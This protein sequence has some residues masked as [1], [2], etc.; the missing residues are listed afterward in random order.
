VCAD[1]TWSWPPAEEVAKGDQ[2]S[3]VIHRRERPGELD[4][5]A[6]RKV[7]PDTGEPVGPSRNVRFT[8]HPRFR[9]GTRVAWTAR[10]TL[11]RAPGHL[12]LSM[13]A[14]WSPGDATYSF[15]LQLD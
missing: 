13:F 10:I 7:D 15:H 5:S 3:I 8:L 9:D 2:A 4:L 6:W 14:G 1:A 11:P 12:Y